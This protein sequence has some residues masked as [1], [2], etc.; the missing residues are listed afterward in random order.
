M[1][2]I[3]KYYLIVLSK[4]ANFI[5]YFI[6]LFFLYFPNDQDYAISAKLLNL[7]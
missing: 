1:I 2:Y 6:N 5:T 3:V 4:I 7:L